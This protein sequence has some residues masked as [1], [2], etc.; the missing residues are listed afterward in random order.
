MTSHFK[1]LIFHL[2]GGDYMLTLVDNAVGGFPLLFVGFLE[3]IIICY[4]YGKKNGQSLR[5]HTC[6][7]HPVT[8]L[9]KIYKTTE[10]SKFFNARSNAEMYDY[11]LCFI[12]FF[13]FKRDIEMMIGDRVCVNV[14]F[15][16]F[17]ACWLLISPL[18]L[19]VKIMNNLLHYLSRSI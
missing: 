1:C 14:C 9:L 16:Y 6:R 15:W 7:Y 11:T 19:L 8:L 18:A 17:G 12:G 10:Y 2:Q 4:V 5:Q 3:L 13:R